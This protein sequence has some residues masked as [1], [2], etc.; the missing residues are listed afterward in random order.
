MTQRDLNCAVARATG[1]SIFTVA[2]WG[3]VPLTVGPVEREPMVFHRD[4]IDAQRHRRLRDHERR[5]SAAA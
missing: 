5:R 1:E 2:G 3:F 4:K